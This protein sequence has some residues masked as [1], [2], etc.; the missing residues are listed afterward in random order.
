MFT[1][2][3]EVVDSI[4]DFEEFALIQQLEGIRNVYRL[5]AAGGTL[6]ADL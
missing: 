5:I 4:G 6:N 1:L 3:P 2:T